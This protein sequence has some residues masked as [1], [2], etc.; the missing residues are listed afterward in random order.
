M[1]SWMLHNGIFIRVGVFLA[2]FGLMATWELLAARR[3]RVVNRGERW[4]SNIGLIVLDTVVVRLLFR[5]AAV[6]MAL[7]AEQLGWGLFNAVPLPY[8]LTVLLAVVLLDLTIYLQH[9]MFHALPTL[10]RF[11]MVHHADIDLDVTTGIRFHPIEMVLSMLIKMSTV[12]LLGAPAVAVLLFEVLLVGLSMFNHANVHV[13]IAVE[14]V[15]RWFIVTPD[16][17]RVHHSIEHRELNSNFGFN[18]SWWDRLFGTYVDQPRKGHLAMTLGLENFR[19]ARWR[20]LW[21]M[22]LMPLANLD[23]VTADDPEATAGGNSEAFAVSGPEASRG[24]RPEA[25]SGECPEGR[26]DKGSEERVG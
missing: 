6:G 12:A 25:D 26:P 2:V 10:W 16:M 13:P 9:V 11:H 7:T 20:S 5:T 21:H 22:F 8:P 3:E 1:S 23:P 15:L 19:E 24:S 14:P 4:I 17:H 18:L